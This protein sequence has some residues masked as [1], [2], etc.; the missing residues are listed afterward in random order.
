MCKKGRS[1]DDV[2]KGSLEFPAHGNR[3]PSPHRTDSIR[4]QDSSTGSTTTRS[5]TFPNAM[6]DSIGSLY[7]DTAP[8]SPTFDEV[9][10]CSYNIHSNMTSMNTSPNP[11][12]KNTIDER[13]DDFVLEENEVK[14]AK[15]EHY[16]TS[17]ASTQ[18][19]TDVLAHFPTHT[20]TFPLSNTY[21]VDRTWPELM[22]MQAG[23][24]VQWKNGAPRRPMPGF[25]ALTPDERPID[26]GGDLLPRVGSTDLPFRSIKISD[27]VSGPAADKECSQG[28]HPS[29]DSSPTSPCSSNNTPATPTPATSS[30]HNTP[31]PPPNTKGRIFVACGSYGDAYYDVMCQAI[32]NLILEHTPTAVL[33][34]LEKPLK[35]AAVWCTERAINMIQEKLCD[36]SCAEKIATDYGEGPLEDSGHG[37]HAPSHGAFASASQKDHRAKRHGESSNRRGDD[38]SEDNTNND[39]DQ[40]RSRTGQQDYRLHTKRGRNGFSC[41]FR[42]RNPLRFNIRDWSNC[43]LQPFEGMSLLKRHIKSCHGLNQSEYVCPRCKKDMAHSESLKQHLTVPLQ[44]MCEPGTDAPVADPEDGITREIDDKLCA[45]G[46]GRKVDSWIVLWRTLFPNDEHIPNHEFDPP[47]GLEEVVNKFYSQQQG[48]LPMGEGWLPLRTRLHACF[49]ANYVTGIDPGDSSGLANEVCHEYI[50]ETLRASAKIPYE[51]SPH[52]DGQSRNSPPR[53]IATPKKHGRAAPRQTKQL[54]NP[55]PREVPTSIVPNQTLMNGRE[56]APSSRPRPVPDMSVGPFGLQNPEA[57]YLNRFPT[58]FQ[59]RPPSMSESTISS[60]S[61]TQP[62]AHHGSATPHLEPSHAAGVMARSVASSYNQA[63]NNY[64]G[65]PNY[66]IDNVPLSN[67]STSGYASL[68]PAP[69]Y[70]PV[71]TSGFTQ[72]QTG[73][74]EVTGDPAMPASED[75]DSPSQFLF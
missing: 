60:G 33:D 38:D 57:G 42:K 66:T 36:I 5:S 9:S 45:R 24:D 14:R 10:Q 43:A 18:M 6:S 53:L 31:S 54:A 64:F 67:S 19:A 16:V 75:C 26:S 28:K 50:S 11:S 32:H 13:L 39:Q 35:M 37:S 34:D 7:M 73:G 1:C 69:N 59:S 23:M 8:A 70:L 29:A 22:H 46:S 65:G 25:L 4:S 3:C 55:L 27:P 2:S 17:A 51:K 12:R 47:V 58:N 52:V 61:M 15:T 48:L 68:P 21:L 49:H 30:L 56:W 63:D 20:K 74:E 71:H 40:E 44:R 72:S 41:P 62:Q